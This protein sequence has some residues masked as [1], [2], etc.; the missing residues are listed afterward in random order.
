[1]SRCEGVITEC[2]VRD[3]LKQVRLNKSPGL[4]GL[5]NE[6]YLRLPHTFV[7]ILA[8]VFN[9][10]FAQ[11]AVPGS[12]NKGEITFVK[13]GSRY[14]WEG[15]DDYRPITML[16]KK[17][18]IL[19]LVLANSLKLVISDLISP[20]QAFTVKGT[21]IQDNLH[22]VPELIEG[23]K[24]SIEAALINLDQSKAFDRVDHRSWAT[25]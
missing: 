8:D 18:K 10:W 14:V 23:I 5:P 13:K 2:E 15:I 17:L 22:L 25:V 16:N 6:V 20:E 1:M 19:A 21:S 11:G 12:L 4:D 3:A 24:D 7:P 9:H